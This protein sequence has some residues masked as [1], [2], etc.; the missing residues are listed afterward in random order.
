GLSAAQRE[1]QQYLRTLFN[2][3]KRTPVMHHGKLQHFSPADGVYVYFRYDGKDTVMVA[4]NKNP[5]TTALALDRFGDFIRAG[6]RGRDALSGK[7][8]ALGTS[9]SLPGKSATIIEIAPR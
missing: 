2:W 4:L 3:R 5:A 6:S 8:V 7:A 1:A 9:L